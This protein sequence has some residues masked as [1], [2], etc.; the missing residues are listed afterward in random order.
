VSQSLCLTFS[1]AFC[2]TVALTGAPPSISQSRTESACCASRREDSQV[3]RVALL[4]EFKGKMNALK[5]SGM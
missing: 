2:E 5:P 3:G 1:D 4:S